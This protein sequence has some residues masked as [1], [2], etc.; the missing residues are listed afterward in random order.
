MSVT[1]K[2][3]DIS[4]GKVFCDFCS[5]TY[6]VKDQSEQSHIRKRL[7][8]DALKEMGYLAYKTA[9]RRYKHGVSV[10]VDMQSEET[11][12]LSCDPWIESSAFFRA[13]FNP[14]KI[15][16][17]DVK[18]L[19]ERVLKSSWVT[20]IL[21]SKF[22]RIDA[23]VDIA[24]VQIDSL[25]LSVPKIQVSRLFCKNGETQTYELGCLEGNI[26]IKFYDKRAEIIAKNHKKQLKDTV[27]GGAL[28]RCEVRLK[29]KALLEELGDITN[30]FL[31]IRVQDYALLP[32][33]DDQLF[34]LTIR[35]AQC[36][37]MQDA[38]LLLDPPDRKKM[39]KKLESA[40]CPWWNGQAIWSNWKHE[41][42]KLAIPPP[43]YKVLHG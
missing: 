38:L 26:I 29:P 22:T 27:P 5:F 39:V 3:P 14:S 32:Q 25:L 17:I 15:N 43:P 13:E 12:R 4:V 6:A 10:R 36:R 16:L 7:S 31:K 30:P 42:V 37:G 11:V 41:L 28:T 23:A 33:L 9:R 18:I 2:N 21:T 20:I 19:I 35:I 24:N 8:A 34:R 40:S 1:F